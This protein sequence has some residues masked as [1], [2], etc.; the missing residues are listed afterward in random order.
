M[1]KTVA[2]VGILLLVAAIAAP[3]M[4]HGPGWGRG[5]HMRG[6]WGGGPGYCAQYGQGYDTLTEE[7]RAELDKLHRK[8][9]EETAP[10]RN[11]IW[12]KRGE[13]NAL[14][15]SP[16]PDAEK[17]KALQKEI[18]DLKAKMAEKRMDTVLEA[19]NINPDAPYGKGWGYGR[20]MRGYGPGMGYGRHMGG[21]GPGMGYGQ[22]MGG[23]GP[24]AC[25]N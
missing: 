16:N 12:A 11:E 1:K 13:L 6:N 19:R 7:Q 20:H 5:G 3:V 15:S 17:A 21:Y 4:A 24:G 25:W 23:Y 10:L 18:S 8:F 2:I 22:H 14:L 9:Y